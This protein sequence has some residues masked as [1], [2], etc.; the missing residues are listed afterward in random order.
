MNFKNVIKSKI[1][2]IYKG[3][4]YSFDVKMNKENET[5]SVDAFINGRQI[6]YETELKYTELNNAIKGTEEIIKKSID[7]REQLIDFFKQ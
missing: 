6:T 7:I 5:Y 4:E 3:T 2:R 1:V